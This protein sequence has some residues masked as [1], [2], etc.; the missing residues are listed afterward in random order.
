MVRR[1]VVLMACIL[2]GAFA[3]GHVLGVVG[4]GPYLPIGSAPSDRHCC[5]RLLRCRHPRR[6]LAWAGREPLQMMT[7][8]PTEARVR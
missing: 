4:A 2:A 8:A 7:E 5:G 6:R 1:V 3:V